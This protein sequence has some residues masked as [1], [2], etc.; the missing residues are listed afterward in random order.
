MSAFLCGRAGL[1]ASWVWGFAEGTLF[2]VVPDVLF[3]L[4]LVVSLKRGLWQFALT[5]AG[6]LVA[7]ALMFAWAEAS[8]V[9][10]R[11]T[12]AAVPFLGEK[13]IGP[14]ETRWDEGGTVSLFRN[15][16]GGGPYKVYAVLAPARLSLA[17]FL[18]ISVPLRAERM[19]LS[20]IVFVP[21][22]VWVRAGGPPRRRFG[23][24]FHHAFWILVYAVYWTVNR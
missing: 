9:R 22:A 24:M 5:V 19:L 15:P 8:P 23:Y 11:A 7:G 10:A 13:I 21:L 14:A 17:E 1:I 3:T 4:T 20:L 18:A 12:V 6:A 16:L 2:F